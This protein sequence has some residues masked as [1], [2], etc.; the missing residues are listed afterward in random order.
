[1]PAEAAALLE[2]RDEDEVASLRAGQLREAGDFAGALRIIES[3]TAK[4]APGTPTWIQLRRSER[5]LAVESGDL[6]RLDAAAAA[7]DAD[8]DPSLQAEG[9]LTPPASHLLAGPRDP[10]TT[11][12]WECL[13]KAGTAN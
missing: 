1:K 5:S 3:Q 4:A 11:A 6:A 13:A 2:G 10:A 12:A 7:L 9:A 8:K